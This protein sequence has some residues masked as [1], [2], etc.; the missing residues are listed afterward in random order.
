MIIYQ[1]ICCP[2]NNVWSAWLE[3]DSWRCI[4][5]ACWWHAVVGSPRQWGPDLIHSRICAWYD[6]TVFQF[7]S[8]Y[9]WSL[10]FAVIESMFGTHEG[11]RWY[12]TTD[13]CFWAQEE[14]LCTSPS[15]L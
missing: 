11:C 12:W 9:L 3:A 4:S 1:F 8:P 5:P 6:L 15:G 2:E 10:R 14:T 7:I 13:V